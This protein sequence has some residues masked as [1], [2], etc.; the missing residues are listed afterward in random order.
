MTETVSTVR[1]A[2]AGRRDDMQP[3][4]SPSA[5]VRTR[6]KSGIPEALLV[7]ATGVLLVALAYAR[8]REGLT[9]AA[10]LFWSGQLL[11]FV[12]V[13]YRVMKPSTAPLERESLVLLFAGAQSVIRW[14]YSPH[15][16]TFSD[17][18][19]HFRSL[20]GVLTTH[21]LFG[22]NYN[23]P[24]SPRYP[25]LQNVTAELSQVSSAEPFVSGTLIAG[26][27]HVL[28][29]ACILLLF[30]EISRSTRIACI[31]VV[32]YMLNPHASYFDTSFLYETVAL[33]FVVLAMLFAI[34]FATRPINRSRNFYGVLACLAIV[35]VTHHVS[36]IAT[37]GLLAI[38]ALATAVFRDSR[39]FAVPLAACAAAAALVAA[40]W[41]LSVAPITLTYLSGPVEVLVDSVAKLWQFDG[42][43]DLPGPPT[44]LFDRVFAPV[45]VLLT[46]GLIGVCI[47]LGRGRPP[48]ERCFAWIALGCYVVVIAMR[49]VVAGGAE[50]AGRLLTFAALFSALAAATALWR[51]SSTAWRLWLVPVKGRLVTA[52][53]LAIVLLLGSI[54]TSLPAWWQRI[55]GQFVIEGFASGIDDIGTYR[56]EWAA[57]NLEPGLRYFGDVTSLTLLSTLAQLDPIDDPGSLYY[58]KRL[59]PENIEHI[60]GHSAI[61]L[62]VDLRMSREVPVGGKYFPDDI[63]EGDWR[64]PIDIARLAKFDN[65]PG[66]S[67]IY[68]SGPVHFYDLR[69][70]QGSPYAY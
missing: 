13:I 63:M 28:L 1:E 67:R 17:E 51:L 62:D 27:S 26:V 6:V 58:T 25:G 60:K 24:I 8:G 4:V 23:L 69:G 19:Q 38:I 10:P 3:D 68:D 7:V 50:L 5:A 39:K 18:L 9:F 42:S 70:G 57:T 30:R 22:T 29:A 12:F 64:Y 44:P 20:D 37:V 33:P 46:V 66:I 40:C 45:G 47:L 59:T 54:T 35:V 55:P 34:R 16:F 14:T 31:G 49:V 32:L 56:A 2:S 65:I 61:Y 36:A 21:H 15:M 43:V 41:I 52:T 11:I 48:L 53:A